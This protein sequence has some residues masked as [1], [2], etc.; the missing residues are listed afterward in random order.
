MK[1]QVATQ[2]WIKDRIMRGA[3]LAVGGVDSLHTEVEAKDEEVEVEPQSQS[4]CHGYLLPEAVKLKLS[5]RL[6]GVVSDSP[7]ITGIHE[8]SAGELPEEPCPVLHVEVELHV[9]GL[10]DEVDG[11]VLSRKSSRPES[12][13]RPSPD[14]VGTS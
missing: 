8:E 4:V 10:V 7:Y 12:P 9:S 5:S 3:L 11:T 14:T 1:R 6:V 2:T 13:D